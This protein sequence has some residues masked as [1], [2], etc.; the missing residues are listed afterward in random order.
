MRLLLSIITGLLLAS[1]A[2]AVPAAKSDQFK[3]DKS[4]TQ[5][6]FKVAHLGF[7]Y[8][9][10]MFNDVNGTF[11]ID[12]KNPGASK[13]EVEI[14]AASVNT[15]HSD[16]DEHLRKA[17]F[18][19]VKKY[20]KITFKSTKV[21]KKAKN[22]YQVTGDLKLH[23]KTKPVT[24]VFNHMK[25]GK[26]HQGKTRTGGVAEFKIKRTD[27]GMNYMAKPGGLGDEIDVVL[28]LEGVL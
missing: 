8:V 27:F 24:F 9:Y 3:I 4:H 2:L 1:P 20:P 5:V 7:S 13:V 25:T 11:N 10:G 26:D 14:G 28:T 17:D 15:L 22:Q 23:G 16:R 18:F 19:D 21:T 12:D 6:V